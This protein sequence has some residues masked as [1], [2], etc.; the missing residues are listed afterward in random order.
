MKTLVEDEKEVSLNSDT[1]EEEKLPPKKTNTVGKLI[2]IQQFLEEFDY[3][4]I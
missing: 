4:D 2:P 3:I 1:E